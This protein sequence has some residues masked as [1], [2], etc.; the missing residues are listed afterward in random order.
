VKNRQI[1]SSQAVHRVTSKKRTTRLSQAYRTVVSLLAFALASEGSL[2]GTIIFPNVGSTIP[3]LAPNIDI[4]AIGANAPIGKILDRVSQNLGLAA[5][6]VDCT[7]KKDVTVN[8]TAVPG[9]PNTF[10]TNIPGLGVR[11]YITKGWNGGFTRAPIS[12]TFSVG[13]TS[14]QHYTQAELVVTGPLGGGTLTTLPSMQIRFSASCAATVDKTQYIKPGSVISTQTCSAT[15][16]SIAVPLQK[17]DEKDLPG[18]GSTAKNTGFD[19]KL[20]CASGTQVYMT[21]ADASNPANRSSNLSLTSDSTAKGVALQVLRGQTLISYGPD[22]AIAGTENQWFLGS[23]AG[24]DLVI[25][26]SA[27]Y[28]RT[29]D[30]LSS[31]TVKGSATFT[32]SYQ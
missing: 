18:I 27:R 2:A 4:A 24:G 10:E 14:T 20:N 9:D 3:D 15:T 29:G 23:A 21:M 13:A 25:P 22:S 32:M 11:F 8:G 26:L 17:A 1:E 5:D 6:A 7:I 30:T 12:E 19:I 16:P 28:I 31:G